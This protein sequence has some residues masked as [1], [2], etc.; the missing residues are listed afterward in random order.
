MIKKMAE[1]SKALAQKKAE[2]AYKESQDQAKMASMTPEQ[3]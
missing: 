2:M 1:E 3:K